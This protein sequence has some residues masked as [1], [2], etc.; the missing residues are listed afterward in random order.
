[1][2]KRTGIQKL[3]NELLKDILDHIEADPDRSVS[4][5]R[6]A[7]LSVESFRPPSPPLP[8]QAQDIGNFRLVCRRFAELGIPHQFTRIATRF[9]RAGFQRL[10]KICSR[11]NLAKHTKKFSYLIPFFFE[12]RIRHLLNS[13]F[14]VS[15]YS[16]LGPERVADLLKHANGDL[17]APDAAYFQKKAE[18]QRNLVQSG[19]DLRVLKKAMLAFRSLQHVQL[20]RLQ[21]EEDASLLDYLRE[22][23]N[24][25]TRP[26]DFAWTPACVHAV[27]TMGE[28][29][30]FAN[31]N[32]TRF[33]GPMMNLQSALVIKDAMPSAVTSL[34]E[35]LTCLELHFDD[36]HDLN[37]KIRELSSYMKAVF[38]AAKNMQAFHIGFPSRRPLEVKLEEVFHHIHWEKLRAFGVQAWRL[39]AEEIIDFARRHRK[40]LRGLRLRDVQLKEGSM[41][42]VVL[43]ALRAEMEQLD[44]VSLRRIDYSS[45][46]DEVW[47]DS[48]EVPDYPPGSASDSDIEDDFHSHVN[49][50]DDVDES[51]G[52]YSSGETD[53]NSDADTDHGPD[54]NELALS[55]DTPASLPFCTCSR[56]SFPAG[57]DDLGDNGRFVLYQQRKL[58][59]KWVIGRCPE[60]SS[61]SSSGWQ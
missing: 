45:H 60:H 52:E 11:P 29:L 1:M 44:W 30:N 51:D 13:K 6:R 34:A 55:P 14:N 54:A 37:E 8:S 9:S 56:S 12:G 3:S 2:P 42:K 35:R 26:V 43:A 59:E 15:L 31:S 10:D 32:F 22:N 28:A 27:K 18:A 23:D 50:E 41:W 53:S 21:N 40:T 48:I 61:N 5:D 49:L 38:I 58:W 4:I 33:S 7:Y 47:A 46:F 57:A 16:N 17:H 24:A 19:E 20:L 25:S 39:D 36:G